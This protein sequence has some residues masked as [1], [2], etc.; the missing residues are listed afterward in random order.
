[1]KIIIGFEEPNS[2]K[3][4]KDLNGIDKNQTGWVRN[5]VIDEKLQYERGEIGL[6]T[7]WELSVSSGALEYA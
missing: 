3:G 1:M 6:F 5:T 4:N 7:E 2:G